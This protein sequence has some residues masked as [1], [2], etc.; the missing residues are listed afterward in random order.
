MQGIVSVSAR[1]QGD[2]HVLVV[3][4]GGLFLGD[5]S[6]WKSFRSKTIK[7]LRNQNPQY[8]FCQSIL[9][10]GHFLM[11][12]NEVFLIELILDSKQ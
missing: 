7:R 6:V 8:K 10:I 1:V 11:A 12:G 2:G 4:Q 3:V 9:D 5:A